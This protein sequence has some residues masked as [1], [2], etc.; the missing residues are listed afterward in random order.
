M[1]CKLIYPKWNKLPGQTTF[2]LPPHGPVV[3][4]QHYRIMW[5]YL[6]PTKTWKLLTLKK[7][8]ILFAS[9]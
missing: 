3:L 1:K 8:A 4:Q 6:L 7:N 9:P 5:K 2:N